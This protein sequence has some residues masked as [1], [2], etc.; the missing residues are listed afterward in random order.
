MML[1]AVLFD[2]DDTLLDWSGFNA[3]WATMEARHLALVADYIRCLGYDFPDL[4]AFASEFRSRTQAAWISART[5]LRAPHLGE[6]LVQSAVALGVPEGALDP[7]ACLEAYRWDAVDGTAIFPETPEVLEQLTAV[8]IRIGIVTNAYQPMWLRDVEIGTHGLLEYFPSC[9]ISAADIGY[10]KP[11]PAIFQAALDCVGARPEETVF[12]GDDPEAD[13]A[14][15]QAAGLQA[16]LRIS[17]RSRGV[18]NSDAVRPDATVHDLR[19]LLVVLDS[20]YPGWRLG[21]GA[22]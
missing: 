15:A 20:W 11:H 5:S 18:I 14:G 2:L 21:S 12:V 8:G 22:A 10:L 17:R 6:V 1:K 4:N 13:I 7:R 3:D 19:E 16:V 9:R